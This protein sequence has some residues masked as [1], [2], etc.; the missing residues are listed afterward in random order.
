MHRTVVGTGPD[1]APL[2]TGFPNAV[3]DL[4]VLFAGDVAGNGHPR[5]HL[6]LWLVGREVRRDDFPGGAVVRGAVD[7]LRAHVDRVRIVRRHLDGRGPL[8]AELQ[9]LR[10][11]ERRVGKECRSR[12]SPY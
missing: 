1:E 12:W 8:E 2:Q 11:E 3:D 9:V 4:V 7:E 10:S 5:N 6:V